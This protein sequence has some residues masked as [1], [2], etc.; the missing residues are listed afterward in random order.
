LDVDGGTTRVLDHVVVDVD[1]R[2][3]TDVDALPARAHVFLVQPEVTVLDRDVLREHRVLHAG[4]HGHMR[5]EVHVVAPDVIDG[6]VVDDRA[7]VVPGDRDPVL[8]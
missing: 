2:A 8:K 6:D 7:V 3:G 1:I 4:D 5:R